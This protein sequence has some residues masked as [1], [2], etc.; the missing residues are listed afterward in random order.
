MARRDRNLRH[1]GRAA[2]VAATAA[3]DPQRNLASASRASNLVG[4]V[5]AFDHCQVIAGAVMLMFCARA[6]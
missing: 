2:N 3:R 4:T 6:H 1:T 5:L